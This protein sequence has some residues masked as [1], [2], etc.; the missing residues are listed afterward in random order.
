[1]ITTYAILI[2][3]PSDWTEGMARMLAA[4]LIDTELP[5][6]VRVG[7]IVADDGRVREGV[8]KMDRQP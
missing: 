7:L 4:R 1:L 3:C 6:T 8:E 5:D 2:D